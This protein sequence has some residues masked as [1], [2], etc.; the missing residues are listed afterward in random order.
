MNAGE[1]E[2]NEVHLHSFDT[3]LFI[4]HNPAQAF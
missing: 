2:D 1:L 3:P 4:A